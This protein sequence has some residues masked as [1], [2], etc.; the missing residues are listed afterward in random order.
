LFELLGD[1]LGKGQEDIP[2]ESMTVF[3][4]VTKSF[5]RQWGV[6][7]V[8]ED[9]PPQNKNEYA[10]VVNKIARCLTHGETLSDFE[11]KGQYLRTDF[12]E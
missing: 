7:E 9:A 4:K 6:V 2:R 10:N 11:L 8:E 3:N 12:L 1:K 5:G